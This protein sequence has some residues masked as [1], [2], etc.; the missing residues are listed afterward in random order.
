MQD[1]NSVKYWND[2]LGKVS[3]CRYEKG[4]TR[5][6]PK[7]LKQLLG[8]PIE[9]LNGENK[10]YMTNAYHDVQ[11]IHIITVEPK[12]MKNGKTLIM[13]YDDD[14]EEGYL[15]VLESTRY[16]LLHW[17][18]FGFDDSPK[19]ANLESKLYE[20]CSYT[21]ALDI[22]KSP[23]SNPIIGW[24]LTLSLAGLGLYYMCKK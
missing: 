9:A 18:R 15:L 20:M 7:E 12:L 17:I 24:G 8:Q 4:V 3:W 6:Q 21:K 5:I 11:G 13:A 16:T 2:V 10:E 22:K 23:L 19:S 14:A 1:D